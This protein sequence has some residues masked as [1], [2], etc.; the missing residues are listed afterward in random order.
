LSEALEWE[1]DSAGPIQYKGKQQM[2]KRKR[3]IQSDEEKTPVSIDPKA[4]PAGNESN[5]DQT[6]TATESTFTWSDLELNVQIGKE[7][8]KLLDGV[9]GYCKPGTLTALVGASGA[10]KSTCK[11]F[12]PYFG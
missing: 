2:F 3:R 12:S 11:T 8:R 9:N 4:P 1:L 7:S 10:G 5:P 6:I